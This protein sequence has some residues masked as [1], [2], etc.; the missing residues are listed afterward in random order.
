MRRYATL[1]PVLSLLLLAACTT[2][3]PE[4][5]SEEK[6]QGQSFVIKGQ[7]RTIPRAYLF[8]FGKDSLNKVDSAVIDGE[9][10]FSLSGKALEPGFYL[11]DVLGQQQ[12]VLVGP[13]DDIDIIAD[14]V[15]GGAMAVAGSKSHKEYHRLETLAREYEVE[16]GNMQKL[17]A[18]KAAIAKNKAQALNAELEVRSQEL[19]RRYARQARSLVD[20]VKTV[21]A[22][23]YA[24]NFLDNVQDR[25][26]L[27][28]LLKNLKNDS[29]AK[30]SRYVQDLVMRLGAIATSTVGRPAPEIKAT[31]SEGKPFQLSALKG[32]VVLI[33]F[34]ASWCGPCRR[35]N[36]GLVEVYNKVK[37]DKVA[38]VGVSLDEKENKW[39][40]AIAKDGLTW[41]HI[42]E[43]KRWDSQAARDFQV[44]EI[45]ANV[46]INP[47]GVVV[48]RNLK[49][50][51]LENAIQQALK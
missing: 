2:S 32:K 7:S 18:E 17:Y 47:A 39:K 11:L 38:F 26:F 40:E 30:N 51:E 24:T 36:P 46:L 5:A 35:D 33:D 21:A 23:V 41:T 16:L 29:I 14:G 13:G 44:N 45:P 37:S 25:L 28:S 8:E 4:K 22:K 50:V 6:P 3:T 42:S 27:D 12:T 15:P 31:T 9:G 48:G 1:L 10:K 19:T 34:W 20:S 43:L 49:G